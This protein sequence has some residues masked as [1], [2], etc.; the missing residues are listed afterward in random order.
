MF[1]YILHISYVKETGESKDHACGA[2]CVVCVHSHMSNFMCVSEV[3]MH[4]HVSSACGMSKFSELS[5]SLSMKNHNSSLKVN[6]RSLIPEP[7]WSEHA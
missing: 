7:N 3:T 5:I 1:S 2:F 4:V 6:E